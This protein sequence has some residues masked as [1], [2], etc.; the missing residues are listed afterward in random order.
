MHE[1]ADLCYQSVPSLPDQARRGRTTIVIA[2]RLSTIRTA[3]VIAGIKGGQ[4]VE[5]GTHSELMRQNGLYCELVTA[6]MTEQ[7]AEQSDGE[8]C[9][10]RGGMVMWR[11]E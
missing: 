7:E 2:H 6:Q 3:N 10:G 9:W 8:C 1:W 5:Q 4:V 11:V